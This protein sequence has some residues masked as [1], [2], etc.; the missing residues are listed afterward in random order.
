LKLTDAQ[1][2]AAQAKSSKYLLSDGGGLFLEV[3][4]AG[5]KY[6]FYR[7]RFPMRPASQALV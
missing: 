6:W 3:D 2:K 1:V 5:R 7:Y 4:S